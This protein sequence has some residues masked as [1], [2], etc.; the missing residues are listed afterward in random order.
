[1]QQDGALEGFG[2]N[3]T[4]GGEEVGLAGVPVSRPARWQHF[5]YA[6]D[7]HVEN[8]WLA[9]DGAKTAARRRMA[10]YWLMG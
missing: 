8:Y 6:S 2:D 5:L 4:L 9:F 7:A 10:G 3:G 1:L